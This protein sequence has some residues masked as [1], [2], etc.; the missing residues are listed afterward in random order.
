M[1]HRPEERTRRAL[2]PL[3]RSPPPPPRHGT[4]RRQRQA[5]YTGAQSACE[6]GSLTGPGLTSLAKLAATE[7]QPPS[8]STSPGLRPQRYTHPPTSVTWVLATE[9][10]PHACE[11]RTLVRHP[12]GS[13]DERI[14]SNAK[15]TQTCGKYT[16]KRY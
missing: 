14:S 15:N 13:E 6:S 3:Q 16:I 4:M 2:L 5:L 10:S 11:A 7:P 8:V 9:T 12:S 1:S